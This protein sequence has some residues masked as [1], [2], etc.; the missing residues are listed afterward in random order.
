MYDSNDEEVGGIVV[1]NSTGCYMCLCER[2]LPYFTPFDSQSLP[3]ANYFYYNSLGNGDNKHVNGHRGKANVYYC[4]SAG[5]YSLIFCRNI[6]H[7]R[8]ARARTHTHTHTHCAYER[9]PRRQQN[10]TEIIINVI[11]QEA[12]G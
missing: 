11:T 4:E 1:F 12:V 2:L 10:F 3:C 7:T 8:S 9:W 6:T 5:D